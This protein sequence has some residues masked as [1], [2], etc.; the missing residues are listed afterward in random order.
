[1]DLPE[2]PGRIGNN[3]VFVPARILPEILERIPPV[4]RCFVE[5]LPP[6][7]ERMASA[8]KKRP[9]IDSFL[10]AVPMDRRRSSPADFGEFEAALHHL[11]ILRLAQVLQHSGGK[12]YP[13]AVQ[14]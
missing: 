12:R 5:T 4:P 3:N 8:E 7:H 6:L 11:R 1:M 2:A 13:A 9:R 10:P 14:A